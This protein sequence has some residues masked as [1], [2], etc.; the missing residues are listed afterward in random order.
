[1]SKAQIRRDIR[2]IQHVMSLHHGPVL[3]QQIY[4]QA[5]E[6]LGKAIN[7]MIDSGMVQELWGDKGRL[8]AR[9]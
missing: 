7:Q 6:G 2:A 1:M 8:L 4:L 3:V 5:G 9:Q